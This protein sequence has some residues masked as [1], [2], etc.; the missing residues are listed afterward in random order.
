MK[1][2]EE[3][4]E[5][6][7][8]AYRAEAGMRIRIGWELLGLPCP[9]CGLTRYVFETR[10]K[11]WVGLLAAI[12]IGTVALYAYRMATLF[13]H[14]PPMTYYEENLLHRLYSH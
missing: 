1:R 8:G 12:C 4:S 9:G 6:R 5:K 7:S 13:P 14:T 10:Q 3:M 11:L 2:F